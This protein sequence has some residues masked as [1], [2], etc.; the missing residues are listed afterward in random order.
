MVYE[1]FFPVN[2]PR[3]PYRSETNRITK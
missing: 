2:I 3:P 1:R